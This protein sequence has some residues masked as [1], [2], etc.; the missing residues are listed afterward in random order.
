ME[1]ADFYQMLYV[2]SSEN[3]SVFYSTQAF[4]WIN[5]FFS[6]MKTCYTSPK[7][8]SVVAND[9]D[10]NISAVIYGDFCDLRY[11]FE[12]LCIL[13]LNSFFDVTNIMVTI[14]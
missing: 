9:C 2:S 7:D 8:I 13:C 6:F 3:C 5:Y 4:S 1:W 12:N 14:C 10:F 11:V